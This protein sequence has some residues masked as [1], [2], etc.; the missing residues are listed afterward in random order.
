MPKVSINLVFD[1]S[2]EGRIY[3]LWRRLEAQGLMVP[4]L[5]GY[6]PHITLSA[7]EAEAPD[8]LIGDL[9]DVA[10]RHRGF[11]V[12]LD[13]VGCFVDHAVLYLGA[14]VSRDLL[15]LHHSVHEHVAATSAAPP[16]AEFLYPDQWVPHL[17]I[18]TGRSIEELP[19][20]LEILLRSYLPIEARGTDITVR[21]HPSTEDYLVLSL[22]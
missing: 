18:A 20:A 3:E 21:V 15:G 1:A 12:R 9:A 4:G 16:V 14:R 22:G 17:T 10:H 5:T 13:T 7:Y 2:S 11:P 8:D 19:A 6:R